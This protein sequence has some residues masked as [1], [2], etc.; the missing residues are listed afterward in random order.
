MFHNLSSPSF[1]FQ[2]IAVVVSLVIHELAHAVTADVL[3]DRTPRLAGRLTLNPVAHFEPLGLLMILFAPIGWAKPV[4]IQASHFRHPRLGLVLTALAG[5]LSNLALAC[6][7]FLI[8]RDLPAVSQMR[9]LYLLA[10]YGASVNVCLCVFN[11]IPIPPLDGSRIVG[12][13]LPYRYE[14]YYHWLEAYGPF[15]LLGA[16]LLLGGVVFGPLFAWSERFVASWFGLY[17]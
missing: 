7:C 14:R 5:P 10:L 6:L 1:L 8:L 15:V 16:V 4:P 13:L 17:G 2:A 11:L 9:F 12:G 3:G